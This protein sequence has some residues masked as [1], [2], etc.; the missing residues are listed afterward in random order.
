[1]IR[2]LAKFDTCLSGRKGI[3]PKLLL[4][5]LWRFRDCLEKMAHTELVDMQEFRDKKA[6]DVLTDGFVIGLTNWNFMS[7]YTWHGDYDYWFPCCRIT[8][9]SEEWKVSIKGVT[10][11]QIRRGEHIE[12]IADLIKK[13]ASVISEMK[14]HRRY[15]DL[16]P[17]IIRGKLIEAANEDLYTAALYRALT[18]DPK[19]ILRKR[20]IDEN[21]SH[22]NVA[23]QYKVPRIKQNKR[24]GCTRI[25]LLL[26]GK[27]KVVIAEAKKVTQS[28]NWKVLAREID[29]RTTY[30]GF[31]EK[32]GYQPKI[33]LILYDSGDS[34]PIRDGWKN[35][36]KGR[37]ESRYLLSES[38][39]LWNDV[40]VNVQKL[41]ETW[42]D[43]KPI[44]NFWDGHA[45]TT[46][47]YRIGSPPKK[48]LR[49]SRDLSR[50]HVVYRKL[51]G[52]Q[53]C[54]K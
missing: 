39:L 51:F 29:E 24:F 28:M 53:D 16:V 5:F 49:I 12:S 34:A 14:R 54:H 33:L 11:R 50:L 30:A 2:Q 15:S 21:Y 46:K 25:D 42:L 19:G 23:T 47:T 32:L 20:V 37:S 48:S 3:A 4:D 9:K 52:K 1:M 26:K 45:K 18:N 35:L 38:P 7:T 13:A 8:R 22:I 27:K 36:V 41:V 44:F 40:R 6:G 31:L 17:E 43:S 10:E